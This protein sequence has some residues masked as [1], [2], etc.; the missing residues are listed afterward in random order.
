[1]KLIVSTEN[2]V[3][4]DK[5]CKNIPHLKISKVVL[6]HCNVVKND[7]HHDSRVLYTFIRNKYLD[8]LLD[9]S[10]KKKIFNDI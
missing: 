3:T 5:K 2:N 8:Q 4:K 6:F 9:I 7:N 1:M 10:Q